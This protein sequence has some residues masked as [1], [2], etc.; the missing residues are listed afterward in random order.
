[1]QKIEILTGKEVLLTR[2]LWEEVFN[3]DSEAFTEY[4]FTH[5]AT[6][7]ICFV[8]KNAEEIVA[9]VHLTPYDI[10]VN[11]KVL[12]VT[13][14]GNDNRVIMPV[15]TYK[16][17]YIVGVA[18]KGTCRHR[19]Y[20]TQ[21][22]EA[23]FQY[24]KKQGVLFTFLMPANPKIYEPF[25]F[26]YIYERTDYELTDSELT[27]CERIDCERS[28]SSV[29]IR[30]AKDKDCALLADFAMARLYE[31]YSFFLK[32]DASYYGLLIH[33]LASQNGGIYMVYVEETF[34]G[35]YLYAKEKD[36]F[37]QEVLLKEEF[38]PLLMGE[39]SSF[40]K[41]VK[42]KKPIIMGKYLGAFPG[43]FKSEEHLFK[44][45]AEGKIQGG[46]I[47]EIV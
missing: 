9:M 19:G 1:M 7:N 30:E 20:M 39:D 5:K 3:E 28:L 46:F 6:H 18:T 17:Y 4:Y 8:I 31:K 41:P 47:N 13:E 32:R 15:K 36:I 43:N 24:M 29:S 33:E 26:Q 40:I 23:A 42:K 10:C 27:A 38:E 2:P 37:I 44:E 21:L 45:I 22:L 25:G 14:N 34:A 11:R 12:E 35:Y 16:T